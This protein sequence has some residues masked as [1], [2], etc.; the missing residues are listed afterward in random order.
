VRCVVL[1]WVKLTL[2]K[3][4]GRRII[5]LSLVTVKSGKLNGDRYDWT[6]RCMVL[7][8]GHE[9]RKGVVCF[10]MHLFMTYVQVKHWYSIMGRGCVCQDRLGDRSFYIPCIGDS[11]AR[12]W[13]R[14]LSV[15]AELILLSQISIWLV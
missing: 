13:L 4:S 8:P 15:D 2:W 11:R 3:V 10:D 5:C 9:G 14:I 1:M 7:R 12:V 6:W